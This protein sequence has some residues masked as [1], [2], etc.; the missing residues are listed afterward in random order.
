MTLLIPRPVRLRPPL[1]LPR[2]RLLIPRLAPTMLDLVRGPGGGLLRMPS[3]AL[4]A[5]AACCDCCPCPS[6]TLPATLTVSILSGTGNCEGCAPYSFPITQEMANPQH[7]TGTSD[8]E[9]CEANLGAAMTCVNGQYSFGMDCL[10]GTITG[11]AVLTVVACDPFE[12]T[13][14]I[15]LDDGAG[16]DTEPPD[17]CCC[18]DLEIEITE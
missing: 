14:T 6:A 10:A 13:C 2:R 8:P 11:S 18:G 15:T 1:L 16:C 9:F 3:G 4:A 17:I 5:S 7:Y 12:A